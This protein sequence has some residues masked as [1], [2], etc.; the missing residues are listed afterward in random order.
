MAPDPEFRRVKDPLEDFIVGPESEDAPEM[1]APVRAA[2]RE[3]LLHIGEDPTREG[4][5][6]TPERVARMFEEVTSGYAIDPV[7]LINAA[8]FDVDYH[9]MVLVKNIEFYSLCEHHML[10][11]FGR[12]HVAYIPE[13]KVIG[14]S[15]IP[16]VVD[17][18]AR[19]LQ[20]QERMTTQIADFLEDVLHPRGVAVVVEA[21]HMCAIMRGV[22]KSQATM[23]TRRLT[24]QFESDLALRAE[25][26]GMITKLLR[27]PTE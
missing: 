12:V 25:F 20:V 5:L 26:L 13:D 23:L 11:F 14:L 7:K 17:M 15:K 21:Q 4:L 19:R 22:R 10:P 16:R 27:N 8:L 6:K 18:Y 3:L 9:D 24:G 1:P 2:V